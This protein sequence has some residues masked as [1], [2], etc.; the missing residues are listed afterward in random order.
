[1]T[2]PFPPPTIRR[3]RCLSRAP[4]LLASLALPACSSGAPSAAPP[5]HYRSPCTETGAAFAGNPLG[6][7]CG[8]LV[9][10]EGRFVTLRGVNA[11]VKGIFDVVWDPTQP[12][13]MPLTGFSAGDATQ[14]RELGFDA[15][16]LPLNWSG[17]EPTESGGFDEAYL[18]Q[19]ATVVGLCRDAGIQVL[20]DLHQDDYSKELGG[21]GAA[22]WAIQ[23]PPTMLGPPPA[24]VNPLMTNQTISAFNTFFGD[25]AEG[26]TLR[27]R[28]IAMAT[29]VAARFAAEPAVIG[30]EIYNEPPADIATLLALYRPALEAF[31]EAMPD[32][33][34]AFEPSAVRNIADRAP[35][36]T[37]SLGPGTAYAPHIYTFVFNEGTTV[38][39]QLMT[40]DDLQPSNESAAEEAASWDAPPLVTEWGYSPDSPHAQDFFTWQSELQEQ[41]QLSSFM[42]VWKELPPADWGCF[43]YDATTQRFTERSWMKKVL[44]RVRPA[45]VAGWPVGYS[46]DRATGVFELTF[47]ADP[48]VTAPHLIAVAPALGP[49]LLVTCD[50]LLAAP[51]SVDAWGTVSVPCGAQDGKSH[52]LRVMV[53]PLP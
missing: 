38:D 2:R 7:K 47:L 32:K 36:G 12:P 33:L 40:K 1:L 19:V 30:L 50:G 25:A 15:L 28:F 44:A 9:D 10:A 6:T 52:L 23:P 18:D 37:G 21:D 24:G 48:A 53:A 13:L 39:Q 8:R 3:M 14:M 46:F 43:D 17:V 49:P 41:Y 34:F 45:A 20:L 26:A 31:R 42:W 27:A 22:L 51:S 35:L 16:R 11:R 5:V 4:V 29:H